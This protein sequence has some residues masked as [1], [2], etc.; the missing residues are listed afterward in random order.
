MDRYASPGTDGHTTSGQCYLI[1][2]QFIRKLGSEA[3][4]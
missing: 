4:G 2:P 1:A 3:L